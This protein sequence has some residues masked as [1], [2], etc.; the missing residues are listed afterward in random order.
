[1]NEYKKDSDKLVEILRLR[2]LPVAFKLLK[3]GEPVPDGVYEP[4]GRIRHCQSVAIARRGN[5]LYLPPRA[6][7]CPDGA[8]IMGLV[9]MSEKLRS[10]ELYLLFKKLPSIQSARE[11][12][13]SRKEF[14]AGTYSATVL[15]PLESARFEPDIVIFSI[16]PEQAMWICCAITY[17]TGA[18]Q[19]FHT[20]GYNSAC[21][22]IVVQVMKSKRMNITFGCYGARAS[23]D[24]GDSEIYLS[25][26][27]SE[28][29]PVV[30]SLEK[31]SQKTIPE[32][33]RRIY[34]PP[35]MD[36]IT[37]SAAAQ[38]KTDLQ[39]D[40]GL[41]NGCGI[42]AAFCPEYVLEIADDKAVAVNPSACCVCYTCVGQCPEKAI[43]LI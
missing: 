23:S 32:A 4:Q 20:S 8:A 7:A 28:L 39:I 34:L 30:N 9:P 31:L 24:M 1:M 11:M 10:G 12:I 19:E 2:W 14:E 27:F 36:K 6:H 3:A 35:V 18:R 13:A 26:P 16:E 40:T 43:R 5:G 38:E 22:D 41:C 37:E 21:S 17:A 29:K 25:L 42:C 33:R 15:A